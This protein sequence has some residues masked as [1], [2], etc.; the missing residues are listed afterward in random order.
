MTAALVHDLRN[1]LMSLRA[2]VKALLVAPEQ[3][4]EIVEDLDRNIVALNDKLSAFLDLTRR[5][6]DF[7]PVDIKDLVDDAMRLAEPFL[8]KQ[9]LKVTT[10]IP[11]DLPMLKVHETSMRDALLNV[12]INA[13]ESG[14][15]EGVIRCR[16][17]KVGDNLEIAVDDRGEGIP[18]KHLTRVFN[19]FYTTR[20]DGNGL[21]LSIVRRVVADH[22][23][24]V[25]AEN[26]AQG[27]ARIVLTLPLQPKEAPHWWKKL[28][29]DYPA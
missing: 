14:Q 3:T 23:G 5:R 18:E 22:H 27:G 21:G 15:Q 6:D 16:V 9:G 19:A 17:R 8:V 25:R 29:K 26:R 1:P 13:G 2:D 28:K 10:D 7:V 4:G 11:S 20:A 12:I 24:S